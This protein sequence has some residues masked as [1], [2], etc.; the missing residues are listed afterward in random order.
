MCTARKGTVW[1]LSKSELLKL[2]I[3]QL[4]ALVDKGETTSVN[5]IQEYIMRIVKYN[6]NGPTLNSILE[7][8][9]RYNIHNR[10]TGFR[11]KSLG[12]L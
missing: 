9:P 3:V 4:A 6:K 12:T 11:T 7:L 2:T 10:M 5:L 8:R 1:V